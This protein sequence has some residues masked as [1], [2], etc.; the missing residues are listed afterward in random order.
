MGHGVHYGAVVAAGLASGAAGAFNIAA[1]L[2]CIG[3]GHATWD[4]IFG[5]RYKSTQEKWAAF[6]VQTLMAGVIGVSVHV[7][8]PHDHGGDN[9]MHHELHAWFQSLPPEM[10]SALASQIQQTLNRLPSALRR[11]F[12]E[13]ARKERLSPTLYYLICTGE[14]P[15]GR[16]VRN[17][18][19]E[20]QIVTDGLLVARGA[21]PTP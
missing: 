7:L 12:V 2:A 14:T 4:R 17:F 9:H 21:M 20:N 10:Q 16:A 3:L 5:G 15:A 6:G 11:D 8:S 1:S 19:K 18:L 13:A